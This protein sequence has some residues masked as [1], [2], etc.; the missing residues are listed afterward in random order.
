[1]RIGANDRGC[2]RR[3]DAL[4]LQE[5]MKRC[6]FAGSIVLPSGSVAIVTSENEKLLERSIG[7]TI[8]ALQIFVDDEVYPE[9]VWVTA[10]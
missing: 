1:M 2:G 8:V 4:P 7:R 3:S 5:E 9:Q 6:V 10:R